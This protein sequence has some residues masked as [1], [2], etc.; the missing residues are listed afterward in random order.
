[1]IDID[2]E[3]SVGQKLIALRT[4]RSL[5]LQQVADRTELSVSFLSQLERDKVNVSVANL[6][7]IGTALN[8]NVA[9]FFGPIRP[10]SKGI[11]TRKSERRQLNLVGTGWQI[12]SLLPE[13]ATRLEAFLVHV[14]PGSV[15]NTAYPHHG[16]EFS[17]VLQGSVR[18]TVGEET[19]VL[20][21]GDTVYHKSNLPHQWQNVGQAEA[22]V[23]TVAT[24][25]AF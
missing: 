1:M 17:M 8:V 7:K 22:V 4:E 9:D 24:P 16:E 18:Y 11:V 21:P 12:E 20:A 19:Y 6:K 14:A 10:Q 25:S 15:D 3:E 5:T 23:L 13:N 2:L